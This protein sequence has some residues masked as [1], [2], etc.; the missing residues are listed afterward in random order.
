MKAAQIR[1]ALFAL[2]DAEAIPF[3]KAL[4]YAQ[5]AS[6]V[7]GIRPAFL[8]AILTQESALGKNVGSCYLSDTNTGAG[9]STKSGNVFSNVMNPNRDVSSFLDITRS[10]GLDPMKTL[11]SC[12]Q[13]VGWGG[14]MGPAQFIASTWML[15]KDRIAKALGVGIPNPWSPPDAFMASAMYLTDLGAY[16]GSYTGEK[17]AACR[18]YSGKSCSTKSINNTYGVQVMNKA[19]TIQ[20]TMIDP[21]QGL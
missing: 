1:A 8:L 6:K 7:T 3:E 5:Q 12:P 20:R 15:L 19:D 17:N 14:A 9:V 13:S 4:A 2:R 18:Y 11:I 16:A 10:L 21:L